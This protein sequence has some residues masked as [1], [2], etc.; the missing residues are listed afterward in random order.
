[1]VATNSAPLSSENSSFDDFV[2]FFVFF[3]DDLRVDFV[4]LEAFGFDGASGSASGAFGSCGGS[5][6]ATVV[7]VTVTAPSGLTTVWT[8]RPSVAGA[9]C[10][11]Q[12]FHVLGSEAS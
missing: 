4:D 10:I 1:M 8:V 3:E 2:V 5:V 12:P 7:I 9:V 6:G 11:L